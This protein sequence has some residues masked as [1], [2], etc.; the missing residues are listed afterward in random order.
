[1]P[2]LSDP[3]LKDFF[4]SGMPFFPILGEYGRQADKVKF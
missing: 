3:G 1:M 2:Q 4:K